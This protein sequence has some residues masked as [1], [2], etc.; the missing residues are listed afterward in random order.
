M[1]ITDVCLLNLCFSVCLCWSVL[2]YPP[3]FSPPPI[4]TPGSPPIPIPGSLPSSQTKLRHQYCR[5]SGPD[6]LQVQQPPGLEEPL[7]QVSWSV[8]QPSACAIQDNDPGGRGAP[9]HGVYVVVYVCFCRYTGS[10]PTPP[11]GSHYTSPSETMWNTGGAY[12]MSQGM[13]VSGKYTHIEDTGRG[14]TQRTYP[15]TLHGAEPT[16][17]MRQNTAVSGKRTDDTQNLTHDSIIRQKHPYSITTK[18]LTKL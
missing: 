4:P 11:P 6:R 9:S 1:C 17:C 7:F 2:N 8:P 5:P 16:H 10:T 12:S 18:C 15:H 13:A 14:H 3:P